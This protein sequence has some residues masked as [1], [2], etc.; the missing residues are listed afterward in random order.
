M[1]QETIIQTARYCRSRAYGVF[2]TYSLRGYD[3]RNSREVDRNKFLKRYLGEREGET[4]ILRILSR[5]LISTP[6]SPQSLTHTWFWWWRTKITQG[7]VGERGRR[8]ERRGVR[9]NYER[10][11]MGS[12]DRGKRYLYLYNA[13]SPGQVQRFRETRILRER[14]RSLRSPWVQRVDLQEIWFWID[15]EDCICNICEPEQYQH[16]GLATNKQ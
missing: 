1:L 3:K 4:S 12:F 10:G 5:S 9:S 15:L 7:L 13:D 11:W 8:R 14:S 6:W 16:F 2:S